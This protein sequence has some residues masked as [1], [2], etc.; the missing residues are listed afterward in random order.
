MCLALASSLVSS[1][2]PLVNTV[3]PS[4]LKLLL[5][6]FVCWLASN[7]AKD[8]EGRMLNVDFPFLDLQVVGKR[9]KEL[10]NGKGLLAVPDYDDYV[11][12][13][14]VSATLMT[15]PIASAMLMTNGVISENDFISTENWSVSIINRYRNLFFRFIAANCWMWRHLQFS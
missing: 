9:A 4:N 12:L 2:P 1:T 8:L 15:V 11:I 10:I 3:L 13:P 7:N 5:P 14:I 6:A